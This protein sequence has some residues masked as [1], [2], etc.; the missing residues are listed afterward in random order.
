[1]P[2]TQSPVYI[3]TR[4]GNCCRWPGDVRL[5]DSDIEQIADYLGM[6]RAEIIDRYMEL[7]SDRT[8]L[9][10][11]EKPDGSCIFLE[12]QNTCSI[13]DA[14]PLQCRL[15][16]NGW[17][18]EGFEDECPAIKLNVRIKRLKKAKPFRWKSVY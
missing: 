12:D 17:N 15:F 5:T 13:N 3:C 2:K 11:T 6:S 4:C 9:T 18:F 14:K 7:T 16:P 10:L 1:M 8:G